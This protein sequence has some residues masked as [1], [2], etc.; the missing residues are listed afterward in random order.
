MPVTTLQRGDEVAIL[1]MSG[2][3][4]QSVIGITQVVY[5]GVALVELSN[6]YVYFSENGEWVNST[7]CI[8]PVTDEHRIAL[9]L[10]RQLV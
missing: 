1:P 2:A 9:S 7:G 6:G 5:I 4:P 3:S 10:Q 8:E